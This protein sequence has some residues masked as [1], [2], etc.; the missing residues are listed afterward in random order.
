[1]ITLKQYIKMLRKIEKKHGGDIPLIDFYFSMGGCDLFSTTGKDLP[2]I[3]ENCEVIANKGEKLKGK[4]QP[5]NKY[6]PCTVNYERYKV[7]LI[8]KGIVL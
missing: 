3:A 1:M 4:K 2:Y 5:K 7:V 6:S 8:E